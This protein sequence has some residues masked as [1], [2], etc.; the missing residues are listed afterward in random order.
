MLVPNAR[1]LVGNYKHSTQHWERFH[2]LQKEA[3]PN[4]DA[5]GLIQ[6]IVTRW[7]ST[8]QMAERLLKLKNFIRLLAA[9]SSTRPGNDLNDYERSMLANIVTKLGPFMSA[10]K[11]LEGRNYV[12]ISLAHAIV[13]ICVKSYK[14]F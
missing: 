12:T 2:N 14:K 9:S 10:Q 8:Y 11:L 6:D 13:K 7:W 1:A 3:G 5:V 4:K